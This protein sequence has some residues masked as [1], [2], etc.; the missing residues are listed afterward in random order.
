MKPD[1]PRAD[2]LPPDL[3]AGIERLSG[4]DLHGVRVHRNSSKPGQ[5]LAH[6]FAEGLDIHAESDKQRHMP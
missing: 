4:L 1:A 5:L 2:D 6:E 3:K